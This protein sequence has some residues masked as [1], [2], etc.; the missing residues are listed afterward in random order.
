[1]N[2]LFLIGGISTLLFSQSALAE[3]RALFSELYHTANKPIYVSRTAP[4]G[5]EVGTIDLGTHTVWRWSNVTGQV[6]VGIY[7]PGMYGNEQN[8]NNRYIKEIN[9]SGVGYALHGT[10]LTPCSGNAYV[11]GVNTIDGNI[12]NRMICSTTQR[13]GEYTVSLKLVFY[14]LKDNVK[15]QVLPANR[16]AMLIIYNNGFQTSDSYGNTEPNISLAPINIISTGCEVLNK[17]ILVPFNKIDKSSFSG[18]GSVS[19]NSVKDFQINLSCDP[20]SPIKITF[21]GTPVNNSMTPGTIALNNP[22]DVNTAKGYGIQV[23]YKNDPIK[24][25]QMMTIEE[26]NVSS[27]NYSIPLQ[28][29]YIQTSNDTQAG[30]A[31]GTLQFNL[32]YH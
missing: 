20:V 6:Q 17:N 22:T 26:K 13:S 5:S 32:Q 21:T 28:A 15:T 3:F 12:S 27:E 18:V 23:K 30:Q 29:A 2:K 9:N 8:Y 1:M 11:D 25:N 10:V 14:K 16:A 31:N 4:I 19:P 24:I 7:L